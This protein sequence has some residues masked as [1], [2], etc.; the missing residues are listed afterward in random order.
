MPYGEPL[1]DARTPLA[2]FFRILLEHLAGRPQ[3][4][5]DARQALHGPGARTAV[6]GLYLA[7]GSAHP[8]GGV[9]VAALGGRLAAREV[10]RDVDGAVLPARAPSRA[11]RVG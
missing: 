8:G 6:R 11:V 7:G 2:D 3:I 9:P 4:R 1:S 10:L 5:H